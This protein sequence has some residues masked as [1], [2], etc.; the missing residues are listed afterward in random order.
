MRELGEHIVR[1]PRSLLETAK[2]WSAAPSSPPLAILEPRSSEEVS[3][4]LAFC[5]RLQIPLAIQGGMTGLVGGANSMPGEAV[6]SLA[7]LNRIEHIDTTAGTALIQA[8]VTLEQLQNAAEEHDWF[9]PLD[10]GAR[11][12]CQ[13]GGNAATNAGGNRVIRYGMMRNAILGLEVILADGTRLE[14]LDTVIKNNAGF[15]LKQLFIGS[16]GQLGVITQLVIQLQPRPTARCTALCALDGLTKSTQLLKLLKGVLPE[17]SAFEV[18]WSD[19]VHESARL[20]GLALPFQAQYPIYVL[21]ETLGHDLSLSVSAVENALQQAL[22]DEV[23]LDAVLAQS[24]QQAQKLWS[25]REGVSEL[26]TALK[27][28]AA[29]DVSVSL[30]KMQALVL[31]LQEELTNR[32]KEQHHLFF[33]HLGDGNLHLISGPYPDPEDLHALEE[34]TYQRIAAYGGSISAEHGIGVVKREFLHHSK[35]KEEI[36]LMAQLKKLLDPKSILNP[37]R[38]IPS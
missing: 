22:L 3:Q 26:L 12:S 23:I 9:F 1:P 31:D 18:M 29:F 16:E 34:L 35:S 36:D 10:L 17:L 2:D 25:Y 14:R 13:L 6:L 30:P 5:N 27:P 19:Y 7:K 4:V 15:D 20:Q 38:V 28:C 32:F 8:G 21:I 37:Q 24:E 33:G 11:G